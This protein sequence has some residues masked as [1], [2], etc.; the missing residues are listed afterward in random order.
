MAEIESIDGRTLEG[1][2]AAAQGTIE[3]VRAAAVSVAAV[4]LV[5]VDSCR[6]A[7]LINGFRVLSNLTESS[8]N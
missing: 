8:S 1:V 6:I 5:L 3:D 7:V 2:G 4:V